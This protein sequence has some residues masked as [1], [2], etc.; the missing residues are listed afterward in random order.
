MCIRAVKTVGQLHVLTDDY[1]STYATVRSSSAPIIIGE[2]ED[3]TYLLHFVELQCVIWF[4]IKVP[5]TEINFL[6]AVKTIYY[7]QQ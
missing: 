1:Q 4:R 6:S 2:L 5:C 3:L 7:L